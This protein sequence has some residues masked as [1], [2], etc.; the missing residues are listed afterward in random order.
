[1]KTQT[2][3][4]VFKEIDLKFNVVK[5]YRN[6]KS[7][8]ACDKIINKLNK[9]NIKKATYIDIDGKTQKIKIKS[10]SHIATLKL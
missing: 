4:V 3:E 5:H 9:R 8:N 10:Y 1:M 6:I 2:L 7:L